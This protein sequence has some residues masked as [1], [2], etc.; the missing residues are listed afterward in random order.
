MS[1]IGEVAFCVDCARS[2]LTSSNLG[3]TDAGLP[4]PRMATKTDANGDALCTKCLDARLARRRAEFALQQEASVAQASEPPRAQRPSLTVEHD[5]TWVRRLSRATAP[6]PVS[7]SKP[8]ATN[9]RSRRQRPTVDA[10]D[11]RAEV[12]Q[13][14]QRRFLE[15]SL[16]LGFSRADD[17]LAKLKALPQVLTRGRFSEGRQTKRRRPSG[18]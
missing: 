7:I 17:L 5:R 6:T 16:E 9:A 10:S 18:A 2:S 11:A 1:L 12:E 4:S 14:L 15:V 8:I 13:G 3:E